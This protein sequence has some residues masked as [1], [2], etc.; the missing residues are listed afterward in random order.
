MSEHGTDNEY[1]QSNKERFYQQD[2]IT[3]WPHGHLIRF[4]NDERRAGLVCVCSGL[5]DALVAAD[6]SEGSFDSEL[7]DQSDESLKPESSLVQKMQ[8]WLCGVLTNKT[9]FM[10]SKDDNDVLDGV[11]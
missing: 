2:V 9:R 6:E 1:V 4:W 10:E 8:T 7:F 11:C 3:D 5:D